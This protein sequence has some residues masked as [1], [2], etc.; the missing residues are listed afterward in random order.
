MKITIVEVNRVSDFPP[1]QNLIR[2]LLKLGHHVCLIS[3]ATDCLP[4]EILD[5][6]L[7]ETH[8]IPWTSPK[9]IFGRV[10]HRF[11]LKR[12]VIKKTRECMMDSDILW[13]TS[14]VTIRE[15]RKEVYRYKHVFQLMELTRYGYLTSLRIKYSLSKIAKKAF[16]VVTPEIN[17]AY[18]EKVWWELEN[19]P[20]VLPNKPFTINPGE[21]TPDIKNS[22]D[23]IRREKRKVILYLG[24][25]FSDRNLDSIAEA[26]S[27]KD[28]CVLYIVGKAFD[29]FGLK[30]INELKTKFNVE[31]LGGF[32]PP[33]HLHFLKYAYAGV[34]PYKP[35][36]SSSSD[37][38]NAL[39]CAP[40]KIFEYA[41]FGVPM[42]GSDVLGLKIPFDKWGIG[43][44]YDDDSV[45]SITSALSKLDQNREEMSKNCLKFYESVNLEEIVKGILEN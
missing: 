44:C 21:I 17:R 30:K 38:L 1:V 10:F 4:K 25:L 22:L 13:T 34:L 11:S 40:N 20:T 2:V 42:I 29:D 5:N 43:F 24:G 33:S 26:V 41:G 3:R 23:K 14:I 7:L 39:Y 9:T 6:E 31:Y 37:E 28:D 36:K 12:Y 19:V 15:L 16:K 18:I 8:E 45:S 27:N 35:T 32:N